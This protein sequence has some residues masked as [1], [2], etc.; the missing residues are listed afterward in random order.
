M[1]NQEVIWPAMAGCSFVAFYFSV[2]KLREFFRSVEMMG[3]ELQQFR[4]DAC[5]YHCCATSHEF[6]KTCDRRILTICIS[7]W[8][9]SIDLFETLMCSEVLACLTGQLLGLTSHLASS[10]GRQAFRKFAASGQPHRKPIL[11]TEPQPRAGKKG[12]RLPGIPEEP[13]QPQPSDSGA[14]PPKLLLYTPARPQTQPST[15]PAATLPTNARPTQT[16]HTSS[17]RGHE[18]ATRTPACRGPQHRPRRQRNHLS[19]RTKADANTCI[20]HNKIPAATIQDSPSQHT[21]AAASTD[22]FIPDNGGPQAPQP[23][24]TEQQLPP[25]VSGAGEMRSWQ[26]V[27]QHLIAIRCIAENY[28]DSQGANVV[29]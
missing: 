1:A 5:L 9:G 19:L 27:E 6:S 11:L 14:S 2:M 23:L 18:T 12:Q 24:P 20:N 21:A 13:P 3:S 28:D 26:R 7:K 16:P 4:L 10:S 15:L 29:R 25:H 8:F 22:N 17:L